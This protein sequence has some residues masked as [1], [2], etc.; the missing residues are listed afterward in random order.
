[1]KNKNSNNPSPFSIT[2]FASDNDIRAAEALA[3]KIWRN[4]Y[5]VILS[6]EQIEFMLR[7]FQSMAAMKE[8]IDAGYHYYLVSDRQKALGYFSFQLRGQE[9][10]L[11]K[12]YI[13]A[14]Y[15][16]KG[17][18]FYAFDF[19]EK[20]ALK[21]GATAITLTV[22]RHNSSALATY[23]RWG[24]VITG[25]LVTDIGNGFVMDDYCLEKQL[26]N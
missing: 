19:I 14:D 13:D 24:M 3:K 22:N 21:L 7:R 4:H 15:R 5:K 23:Q 11:S 16:G 10:F 1:M 8:Q 6:H 20:Q 17:A 26:G 12:I 2:S 18:G 9:L 25:E